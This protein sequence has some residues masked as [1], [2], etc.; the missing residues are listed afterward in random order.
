M[1]GGNYTAGDPEPVGANVTLNTPVSCDA[2]L[3]V[4]FRGADH[5]VAL[6][7]SIKAGEQSVKV[8][9][10]LPRDLPGGEYKFFDAFLTPCDGD[11]DQK[12]IS[13]QGAPQTFLVTAYPTPN[14]YPTGAEVALT[15]SQRQFFDTK[16]LELNGLSVQLTN[17]LEDGAADTPQLH[18]FLIQLVKSARAA[19]DL[20]EQQY[21]T[22]I[23]K[24]EGKSPAFFADLRKQYDDL[25]L[26][27]SNPAPGTTAGS[28]RRPSLVPVQA[29]L[30]KR[31]PQTQP[32][33]NRSGTLPPSAGKVDSTLT[34]NAAAYKYVRTTGRL[35]FDATLKS[36]PTGASVQYRE[37]LDS[38]FTD[39]SSLTNISGA[40][41]ELATYIFKFSKAGCADR[42]LRI[43]P[44]QDPHPDIEVEFNDCIRK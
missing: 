5:I 6:N 30:Q 40:T 26:D 20:T 11:A 19:L 17:H 10:R 12:P 23:M 28:A 25:V 27:L 31:T 4:R 14:R 18:G 1:D 44:Y 34:D 24:S 38:E 36:L 2:Y 3:Y 8:K 42:K 37:V 16:I 33:N 13:L 35:T 39:Y 15:V 32:T 7:T 43:N 29:Q 41:F 22:Q 21:R 9:A